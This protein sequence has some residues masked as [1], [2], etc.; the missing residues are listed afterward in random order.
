MAYTVLK[1]V[2]GAVLLGLIFTACS[3]TQPSVSSQSLNDVAFKS[4]DAPISD[5]QKRQI[6]TSEE[7]TIN[8]KSY[9]IGWHTI[10]RTGQV[11]PSLDGK[12]TEIFGQIKNEAGVPINHKD[13]SPFVCKTSKDGSGP[14]H[15][16][17]HERNGQLYAITQFECGPG[18][19]YISRLEKTAEGGLKAVATS[20]ISQADYYGGW[21]HCA[22]M[23]TPWGS[24]LGSEE[25]EPNARALAKDEYYFNFTLYFKEGE[26]ALN[27]Y[28]WGWMPEV[29]IT[30]DKGDTKYVKH[31]AMGRFA[32]E[33]GYV[34]PDE[35]TVYLTDDGVN[36]ALFMFIA[37]QPKD[38]SAGTLYSAKLE[39]KSDRNGGA[40]NLT[41][42]NLGHASDAQ[43]RSYV[44]KKFSID[45]MF[46]VAKDMNGKC[47]AD[48]RSVNTSWGFECL[49]LKEGM[50]I[51]ASRL[52]ARRYAAYLGATTEFNKKE[53]ITFNPKTNQL[54]IAISR[55]LYGMEDYKKSG[56][57]SDKYDQGGGNHIKL[58]RNDCGGVYRL[59]IA[60]GQKDAN[61]APLASAMVATT[62]VGEV[63]G[64][65]K[66]YPKG[67]DYE[68]NK[69]SVD[70]IAEPDN[71]TFIKNSNLLIIGEDTGL[72]QIDYMWAYN[73]ET[74]K[75]TRIFTTPYG[76]E[77]TSPF[78]YPNIGGNAYL[79]AVVQ[80]PYGESD[81]DKKSSPQDI[82]SWV[83]VV[84]P[85]PA[86]E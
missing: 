30:S 7:V 19:M 83:G 5:A 15:T 76:S 78:W 4:V 64:E 75:L 39:Q 61:G 47:P 71:L 1:S 35:K 26:K 20:P 45:A 18:A 58:P 53:G 77:T 66:T 51:A 59:D 13:G 27:P 21:V 79:T 44:D 37:D 3:T 2:T 62:F 9:K 63:M 24:H 54:Y 48:F 72:R 70:A 46:E 69:C 36:G 49:K 86:F 81:K 12:T 56:E 57:A 67:S 52:E 10:A 40:F 74:K 28:Y 32:H 17:L 33:L 23:K 73:V 68:G 31:Y 60:S 6:L 80:H 43:I 34:M 85:F 50:E 65:M 82:E 38:L 55:V 22:G 11:L 29:T 25:Y 41:W 42:I 16:T 8:G 14:D 84:G